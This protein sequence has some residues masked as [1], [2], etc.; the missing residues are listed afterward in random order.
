MKRVRL[1]CFQTGTDHRDDVVAAV[2]DHFRERSSET[3][4]I[5]GNSCLKPSRTLRELDRFGEETEC[6]GSLRG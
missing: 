1:N 4:L 2:T 3:T 5:V 6:A